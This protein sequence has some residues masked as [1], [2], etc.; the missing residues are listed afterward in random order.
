MKLLLQRRIIPHKKLESLGAANENS[1]DKLEILQ[2][3]V[4]GNGDL[5]NE[6]IKTVIDSV[7]QLRFKRK[8]VLH[9]LGG[10]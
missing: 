3:S 5:I 6:N 1:F 4:I 10:F 2:M 8:L 7:Q 9:G